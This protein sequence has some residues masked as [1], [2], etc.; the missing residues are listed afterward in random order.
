MILVFGKEGQ[1]GTELQRLKNVIALDRNHVDLKNPLDCASLIRSYKPHS[2]INAAAYTDVDKAEKETE[3]ATIINSHAPNIMAQTCADVGIPFIHLSTDYVF[4]GKGQV[5]WKTNDKT[6]PQNRYGLSKLAGEKAICDSGANYAIIRTSWIFSPHRV[7]FVNSM[8]KL[9]KK[10]KLLSV[11]NDQIG[12]PTF[13]KDVASTCLF[14]ALALKKEPKKSG[15]YHFCGKPFISWYDF[16][17]SIF[18]QASYEVEIKPLLS[19]DYPTKAK[20]PLNSRMDCN[21]IKKVF[22]ISQPEWEI[23]LKETLKDLEVIS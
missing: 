8:L 23:G 15:I 6:I 2:V 19:K 21:K 11:V 10:Q 20:R 22:G 9:S 17:K 13:A 16:A 3:T 14:I 4:S 7:N 1:V 18:K 12:G 5:P